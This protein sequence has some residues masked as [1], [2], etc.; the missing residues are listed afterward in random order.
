MKWTF[1]TAVKIA[2]SQWTHKHTQTDTPTQWTK[3]RR[4]NT[5]DIRN[6]S[7]AL[8]LCTIMHIWV[9]THPSKLQQPQQEQLQQQLQQENRQNLYVKKY[10]VKNSVWTGF[11]TQYLDIKKQNQKKNTKKKRTKPKK[12]NLKETMKTFN[13]KKLWYEGP[14]FQ[15]RSLLYTEKN[16]IRNPPLTL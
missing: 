7:P 11:L 13:Q 15:D 9:S 12:K 16:E 3:G 5:P 2:L 4:D 10:Q 8:I 6:T 1:K 14:K